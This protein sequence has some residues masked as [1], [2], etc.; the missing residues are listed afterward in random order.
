MT[1]SYFTLGFLTSWEINDPMSL[2]DDDLSKIEMQY[3]FS[4]FQ[5]K[6]DGH[7][8]LIAKSDSL[9][10]CVGQ[11]DLVEDALKELEENEIAW[12]ETAR[13]VGIFIPE[14]QPVSIADYSVGVAPNVQG[15]ALMYAQ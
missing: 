4:V 6:L 9:K 3:P 12:I 5:S 11:G 8:F 14:I 1:I 10:G 15:K 7:T 13:E 2:K